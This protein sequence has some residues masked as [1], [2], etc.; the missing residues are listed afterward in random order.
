MTML[1]NMNE[2]HSPTKQP[3]GQSFVDDLPHTAAALIYQY[4]DLGSRTSLASVSRWARDLVLRET[5]YVLWR[6]TEQHLGALSS[7]S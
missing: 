6:C 3:R 1:H 4:L 7:V 5:S 2:Q